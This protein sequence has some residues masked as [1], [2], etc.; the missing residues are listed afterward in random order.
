MRRFCL[1]LVSILGL[2]SCTD[3]DA[4]RYRLHSIGGEEVPYSRILFGDEKDTVWTVSGRL[5]LEEDGRFTWGLH[6]RFS[7]D[8]VP[9]EAEPEFHQGSY[10][11]DGGRIYLEFDDS[12]V[13]DESWADA[14][15]GDS[16][17]VFERVDS[18]VFLRR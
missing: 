15:Y 18:A 3:D 2:S 4:Q 12:L 5:D 16:R 1:V 7:Y 14:D 17:I 11:I 9:W 13:V 8:G 6:H 10:V